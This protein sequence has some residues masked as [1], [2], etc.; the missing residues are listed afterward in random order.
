MMFM[1]SKGE[2]KSDLVP[3]T[4]RNLSKQPFVF[5]ELKDTIT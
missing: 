2:W 5:L 3:I 1:A 4:N